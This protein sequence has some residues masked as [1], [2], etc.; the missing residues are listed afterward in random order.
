MTVKERITRYCYD[1]IEQKIP[2]CIKNIWACRRFL[3]DCENEGTEGFSY[4]WNEKNAARYIDKWMPLFNHSKGPLAGKPKI[5]E[6]IECF[7]F[8][9]IYGWVHKNTGL[10]RFRQAYWQVARKNAKSQNMAIMGLYELGAFHEP[11]SEVIVAATKR[12]QTKYVWGEA[13]Y[14]YRRMNEKSLRENF[15]TTYGEIR[16]PKSGSV[17]IRLSE[18]DKKKGDGANPQCGIL[19]QYHAHET[20]EYLDLMTSGMKTRTQPVLFIITTAGF[21]LNNPC[22]K[23]EYNYISK[24]LNPDIDIWNDRYFALVNELDKDENGQL[25]DDLREE[26]TWHKANP[27]LAKT[28]EGLDSIRAEMK[29]AVDKPEKMR[30]FLTKTMN[31]WVNQRDNAYMNTER[32]AA[33]SGILP[34]LRGVCCYVGVDLSAEHDL[35]SCAFEFYHDDK[36]FIHS[37]SFMPGINSTRKCRPIGCGM[38]YGRPADGSR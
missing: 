16:H 18:E 11:C 20:N 2:A 13:D 19:D 3:K 22:Y 30:D 24:I 26:R 38:T 34:D 9:Q 12:E 23:E 36:Y 28:A 5:A 1:C 21:N 6:P 10:R 7:V 35:T 37:H 25:I 4:V 8:G 27:I 17:F 32:F 14:I 29:L 15:N 31:V 33:C